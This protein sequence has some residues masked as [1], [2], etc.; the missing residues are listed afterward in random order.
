MGNN[1]N[2]SKTIVAPAVD[3]DTNLSFFWNIT[4][5]DGFVTIANTTAQNQTVLNLGVDDCSINT[6]VLYNFTI[7]DEADQTSILESGTDNT[8]ARVDLLIFDSGRTVQIANF[9]KKYV[10]T[11]PFSICFN[12]TM[13]SGETYVANVKIKYE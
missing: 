10:T 3:S 2:I 7:V 5:S 8:T 1:F 6:N 4:Q 9:S 11:N 13:N 12:T